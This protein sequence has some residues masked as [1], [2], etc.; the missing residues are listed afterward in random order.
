MICKWFTHAHSGNWFSPLSLPGK[1]FT[2]LIR[3]LDV[4]LHV[5]RCKKEGIQ[6]LF[7]H[8]FRD[9]CAIIWSNN[10]RIFK[11]RNDILSLKVIF[12]LLKS[13][14]TSLGTNY[15][16]SQDM[17]ITTEKEIFVSSCRIANISFSN[18]HL[19]IY[20]LST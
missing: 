8:A 2:E 15:Y 18:Y 12:S 3:F 16:T 17:F 5:Y 19:F 13:Y 10:N 6:T 11:P 20:E 4:S 1:I 14:F 9:I 7:V